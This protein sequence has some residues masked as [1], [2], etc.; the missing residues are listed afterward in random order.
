MSVQPT[1][2]R[3]RER[4]H[5]QIESG[6][7]SRRELHRRNEQ[8]QRELER[9]REQLAEQERA[10]AERDEKI[11]DAEKQ[12]ADA[13]KKI[14]DLERQL[15]LRLQ[16]STTSSKPPSSDGMA[17]S[18]RQRGRK[19][20]SKRKPG[21]QPGH[22]GRNR[23]LVPIERVDTVVQLY[24]DQCN[25]CGRRLSKTGKG[26]EVE[27]EPRR[28]QVTEI[29]EIRAQITE[30][31]CHKVMCP[32][33][34]K[35]TAAS[36]P[37]EVEDGFGPQLT[38]WIVYMTVVCRMPR[39]MVQR[40]LEEALHIDI[41]LGSTQ[42]AWEQASAAV[43]APCEQLREDLKNQ[44]V[45]NGDETGHRTNAEKRWLWVMVARTYVVYMIAASRKA[46]VLVALL[47]KV[48]SGIIGSDR[49]PSYAKYHQ[50]KLQYC[51][52]HFKRNI[53]GA[54]ELAKTTEAERFCRDALA[55]HARL[56]RL[57]HR[58]RGN[59]EARGAPISRE[60]LRIQSIP[61]EKKFFALAERHLDSRDCEVRN[62][63]R[64][65]FVNFQHFFTFIEH[66]GVE[67]TNN[68]AE[69]ALRHAVIW[70]KIMFGNRSE[71]GEVAVARL[72]TVAA[73][74]KMQQRDAL[75]Y[76]TT[77]IRSYRRGEIP[78]SLLSK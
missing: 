25:G 13:E 14:S 38:A 70:R 8:L 29:P 32:D 53:L 20:K 56:F 5:R 15:A 23:A 69:R 36:L 71:A 60:Q 54:L 19:K 58:F 17:G 27:G 48:F 49:C 77:A 7:L 2:R 10:I 51:W 52:A 67:P 6:R 68:S 42:K 3:R 75:A 35:V 44:P 39:R 40:F 64:A 12:I 22:V 59:A 66:E 61:I 43:E 47:G 50:G 37:E 41:S 45:V 11:A 62:L 16:N 33:C 76:L 57:W 34:E 21:G 63:A 24:P 74:C 28:H 65:L 46:E 4:S 30:Y 18:Q 55:L 9:L 73:T 26:V 1:Q 78:P 31:Q 72:L